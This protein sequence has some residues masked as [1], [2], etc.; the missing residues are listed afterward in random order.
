MFTIAGIVKAVASLC[1]VLVWAVMPL[2]AGPRTLDIN[3]PA[4]FEIE[5]DDEP[6]DVTARVARISYLSGTARIRRS[7]SPDWE[8]VTLN[9]PVVEGDEIVLDEGSRVE[10]QLTKDQHL[11]LNENSFLK[12]VGLSDAGVAVS[13]SLGTAYLR[14]LSFDREKSFFEIDA[15]GTTMAVLSAG[16]Y[17]VDAGR[18]GD[19][20]VRAAA[21]N[22]G[23]ARV[24]SGDSVFTLNSGRIARFHIDGPLKGEI[25]TERFAASLDEFDRWSSDRDEIIAAR[26]KN[27]FYDQYYDDEI[28]GAD[29]L[30]DHGQWVHT[31]DYGY[32]WRPSPTAIGRYSDWSPYR[33]GHWRWIPPFGWTWV[34]DEP[35]G[36]ATYHYGR[37]FYH[38]GYW[39]WSPYGYYRSSRSWW[40]PALVVI[41]IIRNSICWY[42]LRYN[43]AHY[44]FNRHHRRRGG[45]NRG[46]GNDR[47]VAPIVP[48][49]GRETVGIVGRVKG[50]NRG[51][52]GRVPPTGVVGVDAKDFGTGIKGIRR[53][54]REIADTALDERTSER[55]PD[56]PKRESLGRGMG[57]EILADRPRG[58]LSGAQARVGAG[59]RDPQTPIDTQERRT[60]AFGGRPVRD[61]RTD[62][63]NSRQPRP[64]GIFER[65]VSPR[66]SPP[67]RTPPQTGGPPERG[68]RRMPPEPKESPERET[69]R[70]PP[71]TGG[72]P[73]REIR[74]M[75]PQPK[76]SPR[77]VPP[78]AA[79]T[80]RRVPPQPK[81]SPRQGQPPTREKPR[82]TPPVKVVPKSD[83][84]A[85]EAPKTERPP[86]PSRK[87][88]P[89]T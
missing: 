40:R 81:E 3:L 2:S 64:T 14:L 62:D 74:R 47:R 61:V 5:Q 16:G 46:G 27:A 86:T 58:D 9:L 38:D 32:V 67:V 70:T 53:M 87:A 18:P 78:P 6:D 73:E 45:D 57:R 68:I 17:R 19:T 39:N 66:L 44:D 54:P 15:P 30:T 43:Q 36:W 49:R 7:D 71:Q 8:N 82:D 1:V 77:Q 88:D 85:K 76:E 48:E 28:Y 31:R 83:P 60:R 22:G 21:I 26:L 79:E 56:L 11:R 84:P 25:E 59:K 12:I 41:T 75:P 24:Y 80:P 4:T 13:L 69:R 50:G 42:P 37:W 65:P 55:L 63:G 72:P 10:I 33:Y 29:D 35:W 34:N 89:I 52:G 20:N 51:P 23:E